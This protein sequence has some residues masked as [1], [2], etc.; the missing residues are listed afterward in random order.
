MIGRQHQQQRIAAAAGQRR[1]RRQRNGGRG[2]PS[3]GLQQNSPGYAFLLQGRRHIKAVLFIADHQR[4]G[5]VRQSRRPIH[6]IAEQG[7]PA[8]VHELLGIQRAGERPKAST[9][10]ATQYNGTQC[11]HENFLSILI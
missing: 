7:M 6:R 1:E 11:E 10:A 2:I 3:L 5:A 8:Q 9:T 4:I